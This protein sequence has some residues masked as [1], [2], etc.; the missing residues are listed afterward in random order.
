[1]SPRAHLHLAAVI[2]LLAGCGSDPGTPMPDGGGGGGGNDG[3]G[4]VNPPVLVSIP[5]GT[6]EMGDHFGFVDPMHPSDEIP[7]H[8]VRLDAFAIGKTEVT[9]RQYAEYLA[10]ALAAGKIEVRNGFVYAKGGAQIFCETRAAVEYSRIGWDG[11]R[12][13]VLDGKEE[14]PMVGLRWFGAAAYCNW[15]SERAGEKPLYDLA[16]GD[17]DLAARGYRIPTE[18][19]WEYAGR[20]GAVNP[21]F[22]YPWGNDVDKARANLPS[23]GDP[24]ETGPN[25]FTT[26][27]GF[28]DGSLRSKAD[29]AWPGAAATYQTKDGRN[30]FGMFDVAGNVWEWVNDWY[31]RD[32]YAQS[33]AANPPGPA[34]A[35]ASPMPDGKKYRNMRGGNWYNGEENGTDGHSRISNRD[36]SYFRGPGDPDAPWF[37]VGLR[38]MHHP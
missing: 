37:H 8:M 31:G 14:H 17:V 10:A 23:S 19:E 29:F 24:F 6:F 34:E 30:G 27:V 25:P 15:L 13:S 21:Y 38:V 7:L 5:A 1:M 12:F 16:T 35:Q 22:N 32:Y 20:G 36:P 26:P 2:V 4:G 3:G 33:P 18:A 11:T 28:Y 9:N